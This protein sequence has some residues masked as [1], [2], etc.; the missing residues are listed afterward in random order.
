MIT[1]DVINA[2]TGRR[3]IRKNTK[4][5]VTE[6]NLQAILEAGRW[7]P[8]GMNNQP[9][10]FVIVRDPEMKNNLSALTHYSRIIKQCNICI[11]VLYD[12]PEGYDRDKDVMSIG[13]C[14]QNMLLAAHSLGIGTVWLGE[15]LNRKSEANSIFSIGDDHEL[16]AV[17]ALGYPAQSP[18]SSRKKLQALIL[19]EFI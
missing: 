8:S 12:T 5:P 14:I 1:N 18:R 10:S 19:K 16:M 6:E 4:K 7:A 3:S 2:I 13:A 9:W 15:I 17:I 11:C